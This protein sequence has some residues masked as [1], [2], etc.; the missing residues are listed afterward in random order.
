MT[1]PKKQKKAKLSG[2]ESDDEWSKRTYYSIIFITINYH[3]WY[4]WTIFCENTLPIYSFV[5][6]TYSVWL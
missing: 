3:I 6:L 2:S 1:K 5:T 4:L